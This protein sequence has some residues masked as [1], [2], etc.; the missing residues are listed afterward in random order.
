MPRIASARRVPCR[1]PASAYARREAGVTVDF[2]H[3]TDLQ[4]NAS[5]MPCC[6][7][8]HCCFRPCRSGPAACRDRTPAP[9]PARRH[10]RSGRHRGRLWWRL[11]TFRWSCRLPLSTRRSMRC[12]RGSWSSS[13]TASR[14]ERFAGTRR[15]WS[16][17]ATALTDKPISRWRTRSAAAGRPSSRP[18]RRGR[19]AGCSARRR[20][21]R[22]SA[23]SSATSWSAR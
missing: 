6:S 19:S 16:C 18:T 7:A 21:R 22:T 10:W 11:D 13:G 20:S 17:C 8:P 15:L 5:S 4:R 9:W 2:L 12:L 1:A 14:R 3:S 23:S